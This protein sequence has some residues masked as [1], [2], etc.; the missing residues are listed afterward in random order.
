MAIVQD[1]VESV[2][3]GL[4]DWDG[5][6]TT[7]A[8]TQSF[9]NDAVQD[10]KNSGWL[11]TLEDDESITFVAN[12]YQYNVP[13]SFAYVKE[14]RVENTRTTPSTWDEIVPKHFWE[15][16]LDSSVPV[17]F[18]HQGFPI[19]VDKKM[20]VIG[21]QRPTIYSSGTVGMAE[22]V[23]EGFESFLRERATAFSLRFQ[24]T[25][26]PSL[27][28]DRTRISLAGAAM[29]QSEIMLSRHPQE[30]R[31]DIGAEHVPGR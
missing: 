28:L 12:T 7:I 5:L 11:L 17:F 29:S 18:I 19:P 31:V 4:R 2:R 13:A 25:G 22:T 9:I 3:S 30:N 10:A 26:N 20:K 24:A 14:L 8:Q 23:D 21:Q 27:E 16:R 6:E 1:I 15:I